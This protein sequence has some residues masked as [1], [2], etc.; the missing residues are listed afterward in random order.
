MNKKQ[1]YILIAVSVCIVICSIVAIASTDWIRC[2][3]AYE[4]MTVESFSKII[5]EE[6][7]FHY[8]DYIF[9]DNLLGDPVVATVSN[10]YKTI[11]SL[12]SYSRFS[13][14]PTRTAA[15]SIQ[16]GMSIHDVVS[17][18]GNPV[19]SYTSGMMTLSFE[20]NDGYLCTTYLGYNKEVTSV[21][22]GPTP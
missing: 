6:R 13:I 1:R 9:Y 22:I 4:G 8:V 5:P 15:E 19:G 21:V 20:L 7:T 2:G 14:Q 17:I 3:G 11:T 16:E 18:L 10:D 12:R